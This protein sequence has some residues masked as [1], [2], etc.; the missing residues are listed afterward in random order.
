MCTDGLA[1]KG[2]GNLD[3]DI[4]MLFRCARIL[5]L[6]CVVFLLL[7]LLLL[8]FFSDLSTGEAYISAQTFYDDLGILAH[9][10]G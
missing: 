6:Y 8:L 10:N 7:L 1:N 5:C 2:V 3:G 9:Q 4:Y